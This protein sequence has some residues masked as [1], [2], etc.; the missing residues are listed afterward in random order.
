M[1]IPDIA[2]LP[3]FAEFR[4]LET[5]LS[6]LIQKYNNLLVS[7]D[8]LN[9]VSLT[10]DHIDAGT[11]NAGIVT[12]RADY[13]GGAFIELS[14]DGIRINDGSK[15]TFLATN[16]GQVTMTGAKV[17][18]TVSSYPRIELNS[19]SHLFK[20][21]A[22]ANNHISVIADSTGQQPA[23]LFSFNGK[24]ALVQNNGTALLIQTPIGQGL[25]IQLSAES[26]IFI[27]TF[28]KVI[29]QSW[30]KIYS[31]ESGT[32]LQQELNSLSARIAAL[33]G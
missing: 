25:G 15:D 16:A 30:S 9:V 10:A 7:L 5:K 1:P 31:N 32:T 33:G 12:V 19:L 6:E 20:A 11:L 14:K 3:P 18:S 26:D 2:G 22:S 29:F 23:L 21:E 13:S 27:S 28:A 24:F 17:Q 8:S 4:D